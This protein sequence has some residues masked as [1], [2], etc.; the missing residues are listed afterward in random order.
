MG[1][2]DHKK[3]TESHSNERTTVLIRES[4]QRQRI[5]DRKGD[6]LERMYLGELWETMYN[7]Y[8]GLSHAKLAIRFLLLIYLETTWD[9]LF[10]GHKQGIRPVK[11]EETWV[12]ASWSAEG[13]HGGLWRS[14]AIHR[15][16]STSAS[17]RCDTIGFVGQRLIVEQV[18]VA[19]LRADQATILK[20][21]LR[22]FGSS[23]KSYYGSLDPV[24][25]T[26]LPL[27]DKATKCVPY[28]CWE[29]KC[30]AQC[31]IRALHDPSNP[32]HNKREQNDHDKWKEKNNKIITAKN[33]SKLTWSQTTTTRINK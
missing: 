17:S 3:E 2:Q 12:C 9:S 19:R 24:K 25:V 10:K 7:L 14:P 21:I 15:K 29:E 18:Y 28:N 1:I 23:T 31:Q 27:W 13:Y 6:N 11:L 30:N 20:D 4:Q 26:G 8:S 33:P 22:D 5:W 32:M 16:K